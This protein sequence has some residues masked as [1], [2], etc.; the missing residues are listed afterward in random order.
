MA[1]Y[2]VVLVCFFDTGSPLFC[3]FNPWPI[4]IYSEFNLCLALTREQMN[5]RTI[6]WLMSAL[7]IRTRI[8]STWLWWV[9]QGY[10]NQFSKTKY[11][12]IIDNSD[13][14]KAWMNECDA[15]PYHTMQCIMCLL[16]RKR[17]NENEHEI[18]CADVVDIRQMKCF[19]KRKKKCVFVWMFCMLIACML[20]SIRLIRFEQQWN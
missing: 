4:H 7:S 10:H 9:F 16:V 5:E 1:I 14:V 6:D 13:P 20:F 12:N 11:N 18:V 3:T 8:C 15:M 19:H 2:C 17:T